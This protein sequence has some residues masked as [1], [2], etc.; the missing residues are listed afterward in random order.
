MSSRGT[1]KLGALKY[2]VCPLLSNI[3][4][5]SLKIL[6]LH[7]KNKP[8]GTYR[9]SISLAVYNLL[10]VYFTWHFY[11]DI[12]L[13]ISFKLTQ[14]SSTFK[15]IRWGFF[16]NFCSVRHPRDTLW[17]SFIYFQVY[18]WLLPSSRVDSS[19]CVRFG[20]SSS[21]HSPVTHNC[22]IY[23]RAMGALLLRFFFLKESPV[24]F[25]L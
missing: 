18:R 8:F 14:L 16:C 10:S 17:W 24:V 5:E 19:S 13:D 20:P 25:V 21:R 9:K 12:L 23:S 1:I 3:S 11:F 15:L 7:L 2:L 22:T 6:L 4:V